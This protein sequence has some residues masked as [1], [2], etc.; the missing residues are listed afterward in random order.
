MTEPA[1]RLMAA[2][3]DPTA[4]VFVAMDSRPTGLTDV[5]PSGLSPLLRALL[6]IDGTVTQFLESYQAEPVNVVLIDQQA[7]TA[8]VSAAWLVCN[9]AEAVLRRRSL[10]V[11]AES[12]QLYAFAESVIVTSRLA[13]GMR[14]GLEAEPG[15][16][17]KIILD[18]ALETRREALWFGSEPARDLPPQVQ[19]YAPSEFLT[20]SYRIFAGGRP[21]M[22]VTERFPWSDSGQS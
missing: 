2:A 18:S 15:G 19:A 7:C 12:N 22:Q 21:M 4:R 20:R 8:D 3:F 14:E 10:L 1:S 9:E 5:A 17:G 6:T 11:G 13:P 16:L